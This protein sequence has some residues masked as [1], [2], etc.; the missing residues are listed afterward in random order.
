M[1]HAQDGTYD[2]STS[3]IEENVVLTVGPI[4]VQF[5][6]FWAPNAQKPQNKAQQE[7]LSYGPWCV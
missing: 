4:L 7:L 2:E 1:L 3:C 6:L 5:R